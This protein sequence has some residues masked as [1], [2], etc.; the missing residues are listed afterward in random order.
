VK[1]SLTERLKGV[2]NKTINYKNGQVEEEA[3]FQRSAVFRRLRAQV[4]ISL[5]PSWDQLS[6]SE[7]D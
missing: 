5:G 1:G 3:V 7:I 2:G 4:E 6:L